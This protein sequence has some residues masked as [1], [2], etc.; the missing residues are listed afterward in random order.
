ML[1]R[2]GGVKVAD[3]GLSRIVAHDSNTGRIT[4][5]NVVMGTFDY[6]SPEQRERTRDVDHRSDIYSLGVVLYELLTG[7]LP[8]GRFEAP[9]ARRQG[10]DT[11]LD[12]VVFKV[13]D[14]D[15]TRRYQRASELSRAVTAIAGDSSGAAEG[16]SVAPLPPA[17]AR[18]R[19]TPA[20]A[21]YDS[22]PRV[23]EPAVSQPMMRL[24]G[25]AL[26][27][28]VVGVIGLLVPACICVPA[29]WLLASGSSEG[30]SSS[31]PAPN[32]PR[33]VKAFTTVPASPATAAPPVPVKDATV[34]DDE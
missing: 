3:F 34:P 13:L 33:P 29:F 12:E 20:R 22:T 27:V 2:Q 4:G 18:A 25:W 8:M 19:S 11:R 30:G 21:A 31:L 5:T 28:I 23:V 16:S 24:P 9:S 14:K 6:M 15:P 26:V 1:D 7:E 10:L 17:S 32:A